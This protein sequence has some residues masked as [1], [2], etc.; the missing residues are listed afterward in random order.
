MS[1]AAK[2]G[3]SVATGAVLGALCLLAWIG[4]E[5]HYRNCLQAA[6]LRYPVAFQQPTSETETQFGIGPQPHFV[7]H[8]EE[9][10]SGAISNCSR[11]P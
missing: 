4:G 6:D 10:R 7:F 8:D 5:L 3:I 1:R 2:L 9:N 11:W